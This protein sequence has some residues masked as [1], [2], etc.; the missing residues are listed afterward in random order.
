MPPRHKVYTLPEALRDE[1][2]SRLFKGGFQHFE[3]LS[4]WLSEQGFDISVSSIHRYA[5]PLKMEYERTMGEVR[6]TM[7]LAKSMASEDDEAAM[8]NST[9]VAAQEL[10]LRLTMDMRRLAS[11]GDPD[12]LDGISKIMARLSKAM[13]SL[14]NVSIRQKEWAAKARQQALEDAAKTVEETAR[15]QGMGEEQVQFWRNKVLGV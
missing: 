4:N 3:E 7:E 10:L 14:G 12:D 13:S 8:V 2:N 6:A 15:A 1:L 9:V 11:Q 5:S